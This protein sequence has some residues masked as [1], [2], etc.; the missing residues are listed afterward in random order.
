MVRMNNEMQELAEREHFLKDSQNKLSKNE[1]IEFELRQ[2]LGVAGAGESVVI[3]VNEE[4]S[5]PED[6]LS[7]SLWD[8]L[9]DLW[10][11]L[12]E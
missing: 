1:G 2:K 12:F 9:Q 3:I 4:M 7:K 5:A 10:H 8:R 6:V 11:F